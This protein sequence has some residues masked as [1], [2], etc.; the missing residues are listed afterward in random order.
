MAPR[1]HYAE[2]TDPDLEHVTR[3]Q[4]IICDVVVAIDL[5]DDEG[6][7]ETVCNH[8]IRDSDLN[9]AIYRLLQGYSA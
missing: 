4:C 7:I 1:E 6:I 9:L 8:C 3:F 5:D 2:I